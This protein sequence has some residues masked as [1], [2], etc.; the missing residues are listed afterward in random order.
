MYQTVDINYDGEIIG[1]GEIRKEGLYYSISC[2]CD[3]SENGMYR[4][5]LQCNGKN[6]NLG[7]CVPEG[8]HFVLRTKI[9]VSMVGEGNLVIFPI[10]KEQANAEIFF[11]VSNT[12]PF[13]HIAFLKDAVLETRGNTVGIRLILKDQISISNPTGQ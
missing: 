5:M 12:E 1:R 7:I 6:F 3:F 10:L 11:P 4:L 13:A 9:P 8:G 2:K